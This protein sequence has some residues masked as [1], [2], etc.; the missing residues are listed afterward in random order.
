MRN[1]IIIGSGPAGLTAAI[2]AARANL[3]P[4]VI[5]GLNVDHQ[6]GGQLMITTE[7][8]NYP[9]F[10]DGI[11]GPKLMERFRAQAERFGTEFKTEDV[12]RCELAGPVKKVWIESEPDVIE[13]RTVI[14]STGAVAKYTGAKGEKELQN[15]GV[16]ACA[17]CDGT[18]FREEHVMVIGGGDTA[19]EEAVYL[20][21]IVKSVTV[22]HRREELR[23]S[24]IM[25]DRA[26]NHKN[27]KFLWNQEIDEFLGV[28]EQRLRAVRLRNTQTGELTEREIGGVFIAIG[29]VP[30]SGIFKGQIDLHD[31][32]YIRTVPG[33][34]QT[35]LEAVYACGDV[36][37]H[38]YRQA[39]TA[40]GTGCMAAI[41]AERYISSHE[42]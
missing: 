18:L 3:K 28:E 29:H 31:N 41:E 36:Q 11:T 20:A 27:I 38:V 16:S 35:S 24:K 30:S 40:A 8:E 42:S 15:Y 4:L 23:A 19:M 10:P 22:V 1:V 33:T 17:T 26:M 6:P 25:Q 39:V 12:V 32:G 9:G 21:N 34:A 14:I 37:D 5:E 7:V 2:Y 13:A